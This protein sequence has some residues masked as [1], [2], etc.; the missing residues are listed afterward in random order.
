MITGG[1]TSPN[2]VKAFVTEYSGI[3]EGEVVSL[4]H[5]NKHCFF[6]II[7]FKSASTNDPCYQELKLGKLLPGGSVKRAGAIAECKAQAS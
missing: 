3:V 2:G 7:D 5:N 6:V 4:C 1:G